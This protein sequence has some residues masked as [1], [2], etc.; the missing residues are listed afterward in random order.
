MGQRQARTAGGFGEP[1]PGDHAL[2][3]VVSNGDQDREADPTAE[4]AFKAAESG[5]SDQASS[6]Y[7]RS[8]W[9]GR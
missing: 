2:M 4:V 3:V 7:K 6:G 5:S 1:D 9:R 8:C